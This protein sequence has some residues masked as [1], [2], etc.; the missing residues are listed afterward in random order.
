[1]TTGTRRAAQKPAN[2]DLP[3]YP[4]KIR[5][6]TIVASMAHSERTFVTMP[7]NGK[8]YYSGMVLTL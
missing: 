5:N 8:A 2:P 4:A 1:M 3:F 7:E 6:M